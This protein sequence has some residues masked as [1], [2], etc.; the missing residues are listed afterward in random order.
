MAAYGPRWPP[1]TRRD[2]GAISI[3][4]RGIEIFIRDRISTA[5]GVAPHRPSARDRLPAARAALIREIQG[6][7]KRG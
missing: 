2:L 6:S 7:P 4:K 3:L 1:G 5:P